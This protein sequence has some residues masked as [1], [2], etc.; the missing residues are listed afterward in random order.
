MLFSESSAIDRIV[1]I[2][3][4]AGGL[5]ALQLILSRLGSMFHYPVLVC[6]HLGVGDEV[7]VVDLLASQTGVRVLL[8]EDKMQIVGGCIYVAPGNYHLQA[9][10]DGTLSLSIDERVCHSRPAIDV[11]FET[12]AEV[13]ED[14]VTAVVLT[15]ANSDG[16]AGVKAVK[17][18]G[19]QVI[20]ESPDSA[21]VSI[22]PKAAI[23]TGCA[24]KILS[25]AGIA[26]YLQQLEQ[27]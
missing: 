10:H 12:A 6:K 1:V 3:A 5:N 17:Q 7:G 23:D 25:L 13:Y 11:L 27:D 4:S 9:E 22:M 18:A 20:V 26:D 14:K 19:G 2:G 8:A 24:D 21:E 15:G 16:A